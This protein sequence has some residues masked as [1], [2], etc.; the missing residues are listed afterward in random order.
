M[1]NRAQFKDQDETN[2]KKDP[3]DINSSCFEILGFDV[4]IDEK[5]KPWLIEINTAPSF[6]T[7]TPFDFKIKKDAVADA[8]Q[9]LRMTYKKKKK[10]IKQEKN[11]LQKRMLQNK[12]KNSAVK[13]IKNNRF[14]HINV[15]STPKSSLMPTESQTLKKNLGKA[16]DLTLGKTRQRLTSAKER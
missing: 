8:I 2:E 5:L 7:D 14:N 11:N 6:A 4:L 10:F 15:Q 12:T 9:L 13:N 3:E 16:E 1:P